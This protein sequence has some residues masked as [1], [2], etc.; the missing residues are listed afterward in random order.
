MAF[1]RLENWW[2]LSRKFS[3]GFFRLIKT[4]CQTNKG[5]PKQDQRHKKPTKNKEENKT[6]PP[7]QKQ[8]KKKTFNPR[9][10]ATACPAAFSLVQIMMESEVSAAEIHWC[11]VNRRGQSRRR[12]KTQFYLLLKIFNLLVHYIPGCSARACT[13]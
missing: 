2:N 6:I 13:P 8:Q 10:T 9:R 3:F 4:N 12:R 5:R 7:Q 1:G 11:E